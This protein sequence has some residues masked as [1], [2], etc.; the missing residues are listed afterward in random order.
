MNLWWGDTIRSNTREDSGLP[1]R[2]R[3]RLQ[4]G[5]WG[6]GSLSDLPAPRRL[7]PQ[8]WLRNGCQIHPCSPASA[9]PP[10]SLPLAFVGPEREFRGATKPTSQGSK[11]YTPGNK[12][13][14]K[15]LRMRVVPSHPDRCSEGLGARAQDREAVGFTPTR[16]SHQE[17]DDN[18]CRWGCRHWNPGAGGWEHRTVQ[19]RGQS[20]AA[21]AKGQ[22]VSTDFPSDL[23]R[24]PQREQSRVHTKT[25][26][27]VLIAAMLTISQTGT[28]P[29]VHQPMKTP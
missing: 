28:Q 23:A 4:T 14:H 5:W 10:A 13:L 9:A 2:R 15:L 20:P 16:T 1:G 17:T 12:R 11:N 6:W 24:P 19:P 21:P 27:G 7:T 8:P 29:H 25:Y 26:S 18:K 3:T 22:R